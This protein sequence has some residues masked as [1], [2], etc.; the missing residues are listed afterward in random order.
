MA[1]IVLL[2]GSIFDNARYTS[3]ESDV[4]SHLRKLLPSGWSSSLVAVDGATAADIPVQVERVPSDAS[5]LILSA[6]GND[7]IM[8]AKHP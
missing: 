5:H 8:N 1:H 2:G 7:A 6:G 3:G 4:N